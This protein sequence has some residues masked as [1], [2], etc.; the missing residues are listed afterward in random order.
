V[1]PGEPVRGTRSRVTR[2]V[3]NAARWREI[4]RRRARRRKT[5]Y[6]RSAHSS[7]ATERIT[8]LPYDD[9]T[10]AAERA[11][12]PRAGAA[13]D[14]ARLYDHSR[15]LATTSIIPLARRSND[16]A[17]CP[18]RLVVA[19]TRRPR[20]RL[21]PKL[22]RCLAGTLS[23]REFTF[24]SMRSAAPLAGSSRRGRFDPPVFAR[25]FRAQDAVAC[26]GLPARRH[27][28]DTRRAFPSRCDDGHTTEETSSDRRRRT[29][30]AA[31]WKRGRHTHTGVGGRR[32]D[33]WATGDDVRRRATMTRER[34][35]T[36][37]RGRSRWWPTAADGW[38]NGRTNER[39]VGWTGGWVNRVRSDQLIATRAATV[40]RRQRLALAPPPVGLH[41]RRLISERLA[42]FLARYLCVE[43]D[44]HVRDIRLLLLQGV[45]LYRARAAP[46]GSDLASVRAWV[47]THVGT[48]ASMTARASTKIFLSLSLSLSRSW[49]FSLSLYSL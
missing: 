22:R 42:R 2:V 29:R 12:D 34:R 28:G 9:V 1:A 4:S 3:L 38:T 15:N 31:R 24:T 44:T 17:R 11:V 8:L 47:R 40:I 25:R 19:A 27:G 23:S 13:A 16:V 46:S 39:M 36:T 20:R 10:T 14:R 43:V 21:D 5:I 32:H 6:T 35:E 30:T 41:M 37:T 7:Q 33:W 48:R 26:R 18:P 49:D 45:R